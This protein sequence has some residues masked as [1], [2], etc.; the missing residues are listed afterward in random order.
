MDDNEKTWLTRKSL[1]PGPSFRTALLWVAIMFICSA[2]WL[3][4][5]HIFP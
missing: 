3:V 4:I 1:A 2:I 5:K